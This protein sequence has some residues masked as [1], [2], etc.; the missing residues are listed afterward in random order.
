MIL[1]KQ[2]NRW[3]CSLAAWCM[4]TGIPFDVALLD[5][6]HDGSEILNPDIPE[7]HGRRGFHTQELV[8]LALKYGDHPVLWEVLP[9][10]QAGTRFYYSPWMDSN[11]SVAQRFKEMHH[12][13][14]TGYG[15]LEGVVRICHHAVAY[16]FGTIY[17]PNGDVYEY[18]KEATEDHFLCG[19]KLW[20][21]G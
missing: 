9:S 8:E 6:G 20:I 4:A 17:D 19:K 3:S 18:S 10:I 11:E 1:R 16:N 12:L 21:F 2:P 15:V 14:S 7:P 5:I 13:I